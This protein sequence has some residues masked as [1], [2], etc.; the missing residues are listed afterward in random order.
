MAQL[1]NGPYYQ[2]AEIRQ[3]RD[4]MAYWLD[5]NRVLNESTDGNRMEIIHQWLDVTVDIDVE[6]KIWV[7]GIPYKDEHDP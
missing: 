6:E 5:R 7:L 3:S 4:N 2:L 1:R